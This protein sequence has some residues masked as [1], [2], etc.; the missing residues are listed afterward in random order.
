MILNFTSIQLHLT[1]IH[2]FLTLSSVLTMLGDWWL[3]IGWSWTVA[4][5]K[6]KL[7]RMD[8][9]EELACHKITTWELAIMIVISF[10]SRLKISRFF[11]LIGWTSS[12]SAVVE[13]DSTRLQRMKEDVGGLSGSW[14]VKLGSFGHIV[15]RYLLFIKYCLTGSKYGVKTKHDI[16]SYDRCCKFVWF[17]WM[18]V[19]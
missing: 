12:W 15:R 11:V 17:G 5:T 13:R 4:M 3:V 9:V 18:E 10:K 14:T 7:F 1:I 6:L 8:L 2:W 16:L 19:I